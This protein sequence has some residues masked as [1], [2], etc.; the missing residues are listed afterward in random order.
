MR[1]WFGCRRNRDSL[2]AATTSEAP[3]GIPKR[4]QQIRGKKK[5]KE[6]Q[7]QEADA[8]DLVRGQ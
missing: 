2:G 3:R 8:S 6:Q 4:G 5:R 7:A 1:K